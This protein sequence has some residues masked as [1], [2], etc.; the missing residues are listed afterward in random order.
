MPL[1]SRQKR[2]LSYPRQS[3]AHRLIPVINMALGRVKATICYFNDL[4]FERPTIND[5]ANLRYRL[6]VSQAFL[7]W[8]DVPDL[9]AFKLGEPN[10]SVQA[11]DDPVLDG[12]TRR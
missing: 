4:L 6:Q 3:S 12:I 5:S 2:M 8:D 11:D 10:S 1:R 7:L 9:V